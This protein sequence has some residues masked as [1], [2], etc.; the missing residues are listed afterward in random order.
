[1]QDWPIP[2]NNSRPKQTNKNSGNKS[3]F[4]YLLTKLVMR[5]FKYKRPVSDLHPTAVRV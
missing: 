3:I 4:F 2:H 1:M 5:I